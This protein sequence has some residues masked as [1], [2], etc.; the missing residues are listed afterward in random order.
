LQSYHGMSFNMSQGKVSQW[1][2]V[3]LA[4][5]RVR[6]EYVMAGVKRLRIVK[7]KI[8]LKKNQIRDR[9]IYG[10]VSSTSLAVCII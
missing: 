4:S 3:L 7:D 8:R 6:V 5:I 10:I 1:L 9:V 2:N